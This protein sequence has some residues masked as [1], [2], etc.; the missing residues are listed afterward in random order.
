MPKSREKTVLRVTVIGLGRF[1]R[2]V[3][4]ALSDIGYEVTAIDLD[5]R[6]VEEASEFVSL[7]TQGD[8]TD[9]DLLRSLQVERS[10]V[11]IVAQGSQIETSVLAPLVLKRLGVPFVVAKATSE[12]H[13]EVLR[14]IGVDRV[15][16]PERDAGVRLAH[17]LAVPRVDD[18]L[19][20]SPTSGIAKFAAPPNLIGRTLAEAQAACGARISVVAL[21]RGRFLITTPSLE[22]RIQERDELVVI[23]PDPEIEAFVDV[24]LPGS[25]P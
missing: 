6:R 20:L 14:R 21:K 3:A 23:G 15:I 19:S 4:R 22:E 7:A 25:R 1:G 13:G 16:F 10:D 2:S 12:L 8:G 24:E 9:E 11:G 5:E 18:Y 17:T